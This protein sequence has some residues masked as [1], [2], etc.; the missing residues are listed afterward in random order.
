MKVA[1]LI[2]FDECCGR[3]IIRAV[4]A[5]ND[6]GAL[7]KDFLRKIGLSA[8]LIKKVKYGGVSVNGTA[9]TMRYTLQAG[10]KIEIALPEEASENVHPKELPLTVLYEDGQVLVVDKPK[11]MPT[12]PSRA[13]SLPTL[14]EAVA[15]YV[16]APFVFRAVN[17][18]DRDTSGIVLI[19][20]NQ[21]SASRLAE[22]MKAGRF[23]KYYTALLS[24]CP[25]EKSGIIDAPIAREEEGSIIRVVREDGKRAVT[26]YEI[27][28]VLPDGRALAYIRLHTGRTHQI[29]V[30]FAHVGAPLY[31][32]FLYGERIE[33]KDYELRCSRLV[34]PH[35]VSREM[36]DIQV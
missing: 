33:G 20:K 25:D 10:D 9:V 19:A 2:S 11:N 23:E 34:F 4:A 3:E 29:R 13:N 14:A 31:A 26:E 36:I 5:E 6:T 22:D 30:H 18:L 1:T 16:N 27:K 35:P 21:F 24:K 12:H 8:T 7:I 15:Y 32:D 17:R 28:E